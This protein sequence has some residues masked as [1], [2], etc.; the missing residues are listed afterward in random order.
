MIYS[1]SIYGYG[2]LG[3]NRRR[4]TAWLAAINTDLPSNER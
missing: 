3:V 1:R 4:V 2:D